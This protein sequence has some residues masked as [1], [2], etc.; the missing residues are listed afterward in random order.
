MAALTS[1][2]ASAAEPRARSLQLLLAC[3]VLWHLQLFACA[4]ERCKGALSERSASFFL[5]GA[6]TLT[7]APASAVE[8]RARGLQLLLDCLALGHSLLFACSEGW[9]QRGDGQRGAAGQGCSSKPAL[10][11]PWKGWLLVKVERLQVM[12]TRLKRALA[13]SQ[14]LSKQAKRGKA[15]LSGAPC[16]FLEVA[17]GA[18]SLSRRSSTSL[19]AFSTG[20]RGGSSALPCCPHPRPPRHLFC[21]QEAAAPPESKQLLHDAFKKPS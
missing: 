19:V 6:A 11:Q 9:L 16:H 4:P 14:A 1:T 18:L 5:E 15:H 2:P 7:S 8:L 21:R 17:S 10:K 20:K 3:L 12:L 13:L